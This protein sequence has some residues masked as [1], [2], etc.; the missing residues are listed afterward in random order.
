MIGPG[1]TPQRLSRVSEVF[2]NG[3][4][5]QD[6]RPKNVLIGSDGHIV[7]TGFD[8]S[9]EFP[10]RSNDIPS[11]PGPEEDPP[12]G[13]PSVGAEAT[14]T[15]CGTTE[16]IAPEVFQGHPYSFEVDWWSF[17][18]MLYEMLSDVVRTASLEGVIC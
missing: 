16:Y 7:L 3:V 1:S 10:R 14:S 8:L 18:T 17:G 15:F 12:D 4:I 6:L 13:T 5:H 2:T 11:T 9:K